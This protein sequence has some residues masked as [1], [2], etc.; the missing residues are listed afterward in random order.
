MNEK[1]T[2]QKIIAKC[3]EDETFKNKLL[4]DPNEILK[5][6]GLDIPEGITVNV[7]ENTALMRTLVIPERPAHQSDS[8]LPEGADRPQVGPNKCAVIVTCW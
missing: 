7:V 5:A 3:W 2:W 6:E 4:A 8:E 1:N